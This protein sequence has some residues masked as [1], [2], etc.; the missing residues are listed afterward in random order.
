MIVV[1]IVIVVSVVVMV[2]MAVNFGYGNDSVGVSAW[3]RV[4]NAYCEFW[5]ENV[6]EWDVLEHL[7]KD[8]YVS[9]VP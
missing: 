2:V 7:N 1:L 5:S 3:G 8:E 6:K 4:R 9:T